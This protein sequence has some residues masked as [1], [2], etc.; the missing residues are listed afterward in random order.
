MQKRLDRLLNDVDVFERPSDMR[1]LE[2]NSLTERVQDVKPGA[3]YF[4]VRGANSDGHD[5][6]REAVQQGAVALVVERML[7]GISIPQVQVGDTRA[8]IAP[9]AAEFYDHPDRKLRIAGV[10]GTNGKTTT[11]Q[12]LASIFRHRGWPTTTIGTLSGQY[13][14]PPAVDLQRM[15]SDAVTRRDHSVVME[16]SSHALDQHRVDS[17]RFNVAVFTNLTQDHLD[18]HKS[19]SR[20]FEA[21][22]LLFE[23]GRSDNAVVNIDDEYGRQLTDRLAIPV[24]TY[25]LSDAKNLVMSAHGST[26]EWEHQSISLRLLGRFNV[27]NALGAATAARA[28]GVQASDIAEALSQVEP[29]RGRMEQVEEG[30]PFTVIVDFAHTPDGLENVLASARALAEPNSGR[31]FVVFGAG[32]DRDVEKRPLMGEVAKRLADFVV[33]TNDNPRTESPEAIV[34]QIL[35]G[36]PDRQNVH[37][38]LDR[39]VAIEQTIQHVSR[40]DVVVIAGKGHETT[41][42][43]NGHKQPFDDGRVVVDAIKKLRRS[44]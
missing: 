35:G 28:A 11:T 44:N 24:L 27:Y 17:V 12:L 34:D 23:P 14:S 31:L 39:K 10:T 9:M 22:T 29:V 1:R 38:F 40:N 3:L 26:F 7:D 33:V 2:V 6:A 4:C 18:Y 20:Y 15:L 37:V 32:G 30:Q 19:M 8:A 36:M 41:Q 43:I 13:T 21:K 25:G 16:V 5:F 42:E